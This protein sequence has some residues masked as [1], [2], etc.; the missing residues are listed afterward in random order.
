M[1]PRSRDKQCRAAHRY[2]RESSSGLTARCVHYGM[3][4]RE[5]E[6]RWRG[7]LHLW[8]R[9]VIEVLYD[10]TEEAA[11][12]T[13]TA[14]RL[15]QSAERRHAARPIPGWRPWSD[16]SIARP[17]PNATRPDHRQEVDDVITLDGRRGETGSGFGRSAD[18]G[19]SDRPGRS[20]IESSSGSFLHRVS[21]RDTRDRKRLQERLGKTI[22]VRKVTEIPRSN[23]ENFRR[24]PSGGNQ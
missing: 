6:G 8:S 5:P 24:A 19:G 3:S 23:V 2:Q 9:L 20:R 10:D 18:S 21:V 12:P 1:S 4:D 17:C 16:D 22:E 7:R 15:H 13:T 14:G 11:P